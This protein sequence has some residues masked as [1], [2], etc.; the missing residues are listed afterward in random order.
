MVE[1]YRIYGDLVEI[2]TTLL[3]EIPRDGFE[4]TCLYEAPAPGVYYYRVMPVDNQDQQT[5]YSPVKS[6]VASANLVLLP[7]VVKAD[8]VL[9]SSPAA[10]QPLTA[11]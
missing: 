11:W 10:G 7:L 1:S 3:A 5:R 9:V 2:P 4:T 6:T 8:E